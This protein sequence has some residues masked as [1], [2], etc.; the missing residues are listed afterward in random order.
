MLTFSLIFFK[1]VAILLNVVVGYVAGRFAKVERDSIASLLFYFIS[2]IV[3]FCIPASASLS[4]SAIGITFVT[5]TISSL[6]CI[7]SYYFFG[8][9]WQDQTRNILALSAGNANCGYFMLPIAASLFDDYTLSI[10]MMA[11]VGVNIYESS[12]GFY[13]S[14]RSISTTKD[15]IRQVLRLPTLNAFI[16]GC[17]FSFTDMTLPDF[18]DDFIYNM[19]STYSVLG[20]MMVGL[21]LSTLPRFEVDVKFTLAAFASKFL[22]FPI[23]I[24]LFI[25]LDKFIFGW[26]DQSY[27][28]AL[29]L[30]FTAPMAANTIVIASIT[31]FHPEKVAATVLMSCLFTLIY[32]P[33]MVTIFLPDLGT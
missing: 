20:M 8:L 22:F 12:V 24:N 14:A 9:Y 11:I 6:L 2:P 27:Y 21:G 28:N 29:Q 16:L 31:K 15:S 7:F 5:F 25:I 13:I 4:V 30:L 33:V 10:Y 18:L 1:I 19:R 32:I 23:A 3:F 17:I 26:Y